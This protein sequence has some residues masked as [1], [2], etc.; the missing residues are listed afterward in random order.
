MGCKERTQCRGAATD[1]KWRRY[2][3]Q[4]CKRVDTINVSCKA[5]MRGSSAATGPEWRRHRVQGCAWEDAAILG[6]MGWACVG[7]TVSG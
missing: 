6:C 5:R 2:R 3:V 1:R 4:G 7:G